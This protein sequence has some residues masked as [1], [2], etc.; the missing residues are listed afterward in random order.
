MALIG[1]EGR[2]QLKQAA[3]V[4]SL[5][6]EVAIALMLGFFAGRWIDRQVGTAFVQ[7]VGLALGAA[8]GVRGLLRVIREA[9]RASRDENIK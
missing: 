7:Y 2:A 3:R 5:G 8:A 1:P 6:L 4:G 9:E